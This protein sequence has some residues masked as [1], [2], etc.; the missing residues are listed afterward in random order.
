MELQ[1]IFFPLRK[2]WWL[3]IASTL[4]AALFSFLATLR[5]PT[6][7]QAHTTLMIGSAISDP[8]PS[9]TEFTLGQQLAAAYADIAKREL[10]RNATMKSLGI[11]S[12]P[13]YTVSTLPNMQILEIF[14]TDTIPE[15]AQAVA[16]ELA[17]QLVLLSP[18][19]AKSQDQERQGFVNQQLDLIESQ[20][21]ETQNEI[22]S[23]QA[24]LGNIVSAK[25]INDAQSQITALQS[26]LS[27]MQ[28]IYANML[29][30]TQQG[31]VNSLTI[32]E[33]A[34]LPSRPL[35]STRGLTVLLASAVGLLLSAS[36]AHL[37]EY[38]DDTVKS[39][40][41]VSRLL[42][43]PIIGH[44]AEDTK[45]ADENV[46]YLMD[47]PRHPIAEAY[48]TLRT[49]LEFSA[50]DQPLKTIFITSANIGD[51]KTSVASNLAVSFAQGGKNV[52]LLDADLRKPGIHEFFSLP[53]DRGLID[54][55]LERSTIGEVIIFKKDQRVAIVTAGE[56]PPNPAELLGSKKMDQILIKLQEIADVVIIDGPPFIVADASILASKVDG[57]LV[58]VRP[59]HTRQSAT[60]AMMEQIKIT[61]ARLVGVTL[62]RI[63]HRGTSYY[64]GKNYISPYSSVYHSTNGNGKVDIEKEEQFSKRTNKIKDAFR[65]V[66]KSNQ[67]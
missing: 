39:P 29:S 22:D 15:R 60:Q 12:L 32:I 43:A 8:N 6:F 42:N 11:T 7:Y 56:P 47:K 58:V 37:L 57:V 51:G 4:V 46:I 18:T 38:I 53:N 24:E 54:T 35:S 48:R 25:E 17:N 50:V 66:F 45:K 19:G 49:N 3:I 62:N 55:F 21:T 61:G 10:V 31:A 33:P 14:V 30:N 9:N 27:S 36:G 28:G 2:W 16:N 44:I 41:D 67:D 40:D 26:K 59:G 64:I 20:I 52:V 63:P 23:K 5:Q 65:K 34:T 1:K 13:D